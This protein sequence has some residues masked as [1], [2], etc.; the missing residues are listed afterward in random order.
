MRRSL[1][2]AA[3]GFLGFCTCASEVLGGQEH[4]HTSPTE[5]DQIDDYVAA[6]LEKGRI[7][8][9]AMAI[10]HGDQILH[11]QTFGVADPSGR[12]VEVDTPF[13]LGS[14]SKPLTATA[15]MQL[16][17]AG[18]VDLDSPVTHYLPWFRAADVE[19][20][21]KI[22]VR[23]LLTHRSGLSEA[24]RRSKLADRDTS[25]LALERHVRGV[26]DVRLV[27]E[28]GSTF[29]YSNTN[30]SVLG[31]IVQTV[32]GKPYESFIQERLF[33]PLQ[34][35]MSFTSQDL[36]QRAGMAT[37]YRYWF[38]YP[39]AAPAMPFV[40][41]ALP[42]GYLISNVRDMAHFLIAHLNEGL[43]SGGRIVSP[44]SLQELHRPVAELAPNRWYAMGW[45]VEQSDQELTLWHNGATPNFY[46]YIALLPERH[47]GIVFVA[48]AV[49]LFV[50]DEFNAIPQGVVAMLRGMSPEIGA[51]APFHPPLSFPLV[52]TLPIFMLQLLWILIHAIARRF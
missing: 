11:M 12:A 26:R 35:N 52:Y 17:D 10:V 37:G 5:L 8:G 3:C 7:P 23:D 22:T 31:L 33:G 19:A 18:H 43:Y 1:T 38:G 25:S 6:R 44:A 27:H 46:S 50:T 13:I 20:S 21:A 34:M 24:T 2:L 41:W 48:N 51:D 40:R 39:R 9:A 36:A 49:D 32:A 29:E 15:V 16:V 4:D 47:L 45:A 30:Y 28:P 42:G 14:T